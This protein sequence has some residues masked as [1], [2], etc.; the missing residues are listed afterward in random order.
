MGTPKLN[1]P[2][3]QCKG[4]GKNAEKKKGGKYPQRR[5]FHIWGRKGLNKKDIFLSLMK[6]RGGVSERREK[7][8]EV[9]A[10]K[11]REGKGP[12]SCQV[13]GKKKKKNGRL[14]SGTTDSHTCGHVKKGKEG[15]P[16]PLPTL[17]DQGIGSV[18]AAIKEET[19]PQ[20]D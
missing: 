6:N 13:W 11:K 16:T 4:R 20:E 2:K 5:F 14:K 19:R 1:P 12:P 9:L 17:K 18:I 8:Q 15:R 3:I 10:Q 7:G